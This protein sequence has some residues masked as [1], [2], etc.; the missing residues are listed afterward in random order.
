MNAKSLL[1][2][3]LFAGACLALLVAAGMAAGQDAGAEP[4]AP[5]PKR[6]A[7]ASTTI[8]LYPEADTWIDGEFVDNNYGT[9][10]LLVVG[11]D[12]CPGVEFPHLGRAMLR[13][14]LSSIPPG[15]IIESAT[16]SLYSRYMTSDP[17]SSNLI[18]TAHLV[19]YPWGET[20]ITWHDTPDYTTAYSG[21]NVGPGLGVYYD[22]DATSMVTAWY[23]GEHDNN[24]L[25]LVSSQESSCNQR[26]FDSR[27]GANDPVLQVTYGEATAT[28][29]HTATKTRT[30]TVTP[31][32]SK[33]PTGT[34]LPSPTA[35]KTPTATATK[36]KTGTPTKTPTPGV[37]FTVDNVEITQTIQDLN[38]TVTLI[39]D[40]RTFARA[41][42]HASTGN[43]ANVLGKF[44]IVRGGTHGPYVA[45]NPGARITVRAAP[46]RAQINDSFWFEIPP[47]LLGAGSVQICAEVNPDHFVPENN[48]GNNTLCRTVNLV[49]SP[50]AK[51]HIY[52]VKYKVGSTTHEATWD[53]VSHLITWMRSEYPIPNLEWTWSTLDWTKTMTPGLAGCTAVNT[54]L[55]ALRKT[56]GNPARWRYY[57]MVTD[58]GGWMTGCA[59]NIPSFA[60]SGPTGN[61]AN[62]TNTNWDTDTSFG[63]WYGTHELGHTYN[64]FHAMF[65]GA[66]GGVAYPYPN[67][68]IGGPTGNT[69]RYFGW[70]ADLRQV[71]PST[72]T[73]M[74]TYCAD[75]WVS[76]FTYNALRS[77]LV[78]EGTGSA[79]EVAARSAASQLLVLGQADLTAGTAELWPLYVMP[80]LPVEEPIPGADWA[81]V[82]RA[83]N[84]S[85]LAAYPFT[86]RQNVAGSG[87]GPAPKASIAET[88]PWNGDTRSIAILYRGSEVAVRSRSDHTPSVTVAYPN[89]GESL[90]EGE[91]LVRWTA[92]DTD[93]DTLTFVLQYSPD[94]GAT[95]QTVVTGL[96]V[97]SYNVALDSLPG[98][99]AALFR[100]I[101]TDGVNTKVDASN[102]TFRVRRKPPRVFITSP[103]NGAHFTAEQQVM[104]IG[105]AY[106][107]E[108]G[109]ISG[110]HLYWQL[111]GGDIVGTGARFSLMGLP[112]GR[113]TI[114][115]WAADNNEQEGSA[116]VVVYVGETQPR[117]YLP[118]VMKR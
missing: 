12:D 51:V 44:T 70:N 111:D 15:Q 110:E 29:T 18:I 72:W 5:Q 52:T 116:T 45:D 75:E 77:R 95:W 76:D 4:S 32:A 35:S 16:L 6:P 98:S 80:N 40:K 39:A 71:V 42:V 46:N 33:T 66:G 83:G 81:I 31:T 104:L 21:K 10:N 82:L 117:K 105:D 106:D 73:D 49:T 99:D 93:G 22:W 17:P 30:P 24:G 113:H 57:G 115:L 74:M 109:L 89:G 94:A 41:H 90:A 68:I 8:P 14:N 56:D 67:G 54:E 91:V 38:N 63:D 108:D 61:P 50:P 65:C 86:P 114:T 26:Q 101:A 60:A 92:G 7:A 107:A 100:V 3:V 36:T 96:Q 118:V 97:K 37:D 79:A 87:P 2:R 69:N 19:R 23:T 47:N 53:D 28:P 48:Y 20:T 64:R 112:Q 27:E 103:L 43:H 58:T 34:L 62:W 9:Q 59:E 11:S 13:F 88:V 102:A 84:G 55:L 25:I 85:V 1:G 78:S